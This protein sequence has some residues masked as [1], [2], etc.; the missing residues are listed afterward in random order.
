MTLQL[1]QYLY[2]FSS[3]QPVL[4]CGPSITK[5]IIIILTWPC[6]CPNCCCCCSNCCCCCCPNCCCCC[7]NCCCCCLDCLTAASTGS[8]CKNDKHLLFRS[9]CNYLY[10]F[11]RYLRFLSLLPGSWEEQLSVLSLLLLLLLRSEM[12][13]IF[14]INYHL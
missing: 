6:C 4:T 7:P 13:E 8:L 3:V 11:E 12:N 5:Q 2:A 9:I 14:F 1:R 10:R